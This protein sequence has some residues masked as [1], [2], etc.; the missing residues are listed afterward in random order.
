MLT[1]SLHI[2]SCIESFECETETFFTQPIVPIDWKN[3]GVTQTYFQIE[4]FSPLSVTQ[5]NSIADL[6]NTEIQGGRRIYLHCKAGRGRSVMAAT[7]Y[8]IKY[9]KKDFIQAKEL[10]A[11]K[12][13]S[14]MNASQVEIFKEFAETL[15]NR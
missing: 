1:R 3:E 7:A 5:L 8:M 4:G 12:R 13:P 14:W 11:S 2:I 9:E 6:I 10:V 15:K